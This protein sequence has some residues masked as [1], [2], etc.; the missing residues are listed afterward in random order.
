MHEEFQ[1]SERCREPE[2][3]QQTSLPNHNDR[4]TIPPPPHIYRSGLHSNF[5]QPKKK[6]TT[7]LDLDLD[8]IH[9]RFYCH[10]GAFHK[11]SYLLPGFKSVIGDSKM[12]TRVEE[13]KTAS[14]EVVKAV[15]PDRDGHKVS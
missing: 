9:D 14:S 12:E 6:A 3:M 11:C 13:S 4:A 10:R 15:S 8:E 2:Q 5:Y 7:L 1:S